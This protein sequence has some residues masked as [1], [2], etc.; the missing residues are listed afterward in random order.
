MALRG[1]GPEARLLDPESDQVHSLSI[2]TRRLPKHA[3][4]TSFVIFSAP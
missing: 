1:E 3:R 2:G 4:P